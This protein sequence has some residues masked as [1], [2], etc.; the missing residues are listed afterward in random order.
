MHVCNEALLV[1]HETFVMKHSRVFRVCHVSHSYVC[2]HMCDI[3]V[4]NE[5]HSETNSDTYMYLT[6]SDTYMY[7]TNSHTYMYLTNSHT[8]MY[9]F[10]YTMYAQCNGTIYVTQHCVMKQIHICVTICFIS[11]LY[12][13]HTCVQWNT[14]MCAMKHI[15]VCNE[16]FAC[17]KRL[18]FESCDIAE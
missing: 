15:H 10:H 6:N 4:C 8:Y 1:C 12:V 3:R 2:I 13:W 9:L 5:I 11:H 17:L 7:L 14:Y 18:I 16:T